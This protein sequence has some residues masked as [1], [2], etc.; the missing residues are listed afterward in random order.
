MKK[1]LITGA[2]GFIGK[3][4]LFAL[5]DYKVLLFDKDYTYEYLDTVLG[6]V[7]FIFH[8][9]SGIKDGYDTTLSQF[10]ISA[11]DRHDNYPPV[12]YT[13]SI[14]A[15][16][17][18]PHGRYKRLEEELWKWYK[19]HV[20]IYRLANVFG[21]WAKPEYNSVVSTFLFNQLYGLDFRIDEAT[22]DLSL[23][24]IDDVVSEFR[25]VMEGTVERTPREYLS[26]HP[27]YKI[28]V[29]QLSNAIQGLDDFYGNCRDTDIDHEL[30]NKLYQT[31]QR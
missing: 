25:N 9:A 7:D 16:S 15:T 4:L 1:L 24:Y 21:R 29:G 23:V 8:L 11:L 17:D 26:V 12:I 10:I 18:T 2:N 20:Y 27:V 28:T 22:H 5:Q 3:N 6:D 31:Y 13:S 14:L 30:L 19:G